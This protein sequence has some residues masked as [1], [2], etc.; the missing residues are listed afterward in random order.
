MPDAIYTGGGYLKVIKE[1]AAVPV[2]PDTVVNL[3]ESVVGREDVAVVG[4]DVCGYDDADRDRPC[5]RAAGWGTD[6]DSGRCDD[7]REGE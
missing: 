5:L 6:S 3:P 7:H 1:N 2:Q 4:E